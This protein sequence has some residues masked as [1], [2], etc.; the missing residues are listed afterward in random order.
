MPVEEVAFL[1]HRLTVWA[2]R[3]LH[4]LNVTETSQ[5]EIEE[6]TP[7]LTPGA[8]YY[9][10]LLRDAFDDFP[11]EPLPLPPPVPELPAMASA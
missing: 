1:A 7:V 9:A 6:L 2:P 10:N 5:A 8:I 4:Y 11:D 3:L